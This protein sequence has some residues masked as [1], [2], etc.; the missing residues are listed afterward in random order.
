MNGKVA[1]L[2]KKAQLSLND[3]KK[4]KRPFFKCTPADFSSLFLLAANTELAKR[5]FKTE[6]LI[7]DGNKEIINQ[8]Y[9]YFIG[10][11]KFKG[12]LQKG[13]FL[14][15]TLGVG[16]TLIMRAFCSVWNSFRQTIITRY[17]SRECAEL[18][19]K[20]IP[21]FAK[22]GD[23]P[24]IDHFKAPI[25]IDDI[26]KEP[27][28]VI[29]WGT[30][31]CPMNELLCKRYDAFS[32]TFATGN[33]NLNTLSEHYNETTADRMKEMFNIIPLKGSSRRK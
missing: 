19:I 9:F 17:T 22:E 1:D 5:N 8:L 12:D 26:G 25:Y 24:K 31:I 30:E 3:A 20:N 16:K 7:D 2:I 21:A 33:Y 4:S 18:I 32:L 23:F 29:E 27:L 10:S 14:G 28:K 15:G 13:I 6:F 11:E